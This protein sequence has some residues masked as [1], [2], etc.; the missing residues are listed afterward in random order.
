MNREE[1][2]VR[3]LLAP[4][5]SLFRLSISSSSASQRLVTALTE[6]D[7]DK[8]TNKQTITIS[9]IFLRLKP[10]I[11]YVLFESWHCNSWR[12][13][14]NNQKLELGLK[15]HFT[16]TFVKNNNNIDTYILKS[17]NLS[18]QQE[19]LQFPVTLRR[20]P[21]CLNVY[22]LLAFSWYP[23]YDQVVLKALYTCPELSV[24]IQYLAMLYVLDILSSGQYFGERRRWML[25]LE[26][27]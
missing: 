7:L 25:S 6:T 8:P 10:R 22:L 12:C 26:S 18:Q 11:N 15:I 23:R 24:S 19:K 4:S 27:T 9:E 3:M 2:S 14:S 1:Y 17:T 16:D 21:L 5:P 13:S 20:S